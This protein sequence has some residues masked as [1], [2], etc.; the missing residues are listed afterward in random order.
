M[1]KLTLASF[2]LLR[3]REDT[4]KHDGIYALPQNSSDLK[5]AIRTR[6]SGLGLFVMEKKSR[7]DFK[8]YRLLPLSARENE[9]QD[10][11]KY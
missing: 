6:L 1:E 3:N 11:I 8:E 9:I 10:K 7:N 2:F 5:S 4:L